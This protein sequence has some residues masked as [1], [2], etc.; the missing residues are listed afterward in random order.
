M[1]K[2]KRKS[3]ALS[4]FQ[5]QLKQRS[6]ARLHE[7]FDAKGGSFNEADYKNTATPLRFIC[8]EGHERRMQPSAI[9]AGAWCLEC[10][11]K[12]YSGQH[13]KLKDG[14][15]QAH[16]IAES[17]GGK[18]LSTEYVRSDVPLLWECANGHQWQA[19]FH[20]VK[21][22]TWCPTCGSGYRERLC[23]HYFE[24]IT[25][26]KFPKAKPEW[27]INT[28]GGRMELDGYSEQLSLAFEHHG[29]QHYAGIKHFTRRDETLKKR[30]EDDATRRNLC[31]ANNITLI[32]VPYTVLD[33]ELPNFI[34]D[35]IKAARPGIKLIA[36]SKLKLVP[37]VASNELAELKQIA[38]DMGGECLSN[39]YHGVFS[40]HDFRCEKG[41]EWSAKPTNIKRGTWCPVCKPERIGASNRK[42]T[43]KDMQELAAKRGGQF[44]SSEFKS[45]NEKYNWIC[46]AGH[47]WVAK[48]AGIFHGEWCAK[49]AHDSHRDT[50]EE[51]RRIARERGG[52]CLSTEYIGQHDKIKFEC[53]EGHKFEIRPSNLKSHGSWCVQ[54]KE[55]ARLLERLKEMHE[56]AKKHEGKLL[57]TEY[58]TGKMKWVCK[59][60]HI[61]EQKG[62]NIKCTGSWCSKCGY[63][64]RK[65]TKDQSLP[66]Y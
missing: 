14:L 25:N 10:F 63:I 9:L 56:L 47:K 37:Y 59:R 28:R 21:R 15:E 60:G 45:V 2:K 3:Q 17:K 39:I 36:R 34:Y 11:K 7:I 38:I 31:V 20:D 53:A 54:C 12:N 16:R 30:I 66:T 6:I 65:R 24:T 26:T 44:L 19:V 43:V 49:C 5:I 22:R 48:P 1:S 8:G 61:F 41:H 51:M 52:K 29:K 27:L 46:S 62:A 57:S 55:N 32:E 64:D 23:R 40:Y 4:A 33:A 42:Y 13:L 18:C 35:Q 50:I 58:S